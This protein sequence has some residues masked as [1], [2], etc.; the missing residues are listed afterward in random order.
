MVDYTSTSGYV[1]DDKGRRQYIDRNDAA[2]V[3]GTYL[4]ASD[5][6]QDRNAIMD[7][8]ITA[9]LKGSAD[10]DT[11]LTR[12]IVIL[13][14]KSAESIQENL[15]SEAQTR[16]SA[17]KQLQST[18]QDMLGFVPVSGQWA[19]GTTSY[20]VLGL[21]YLI[22]ALRPQCFY[23]DAD[24][25]QHT[26]GVLALESDVNSEA[27]ARESADAG[28][29]GNI[30]AEAAARA[31]AIAQC[32]SGVWAIG[33]TAYQITGLTHLISAERP[34]YFYQD[35]RGAQ[36]AGGTLALESDVTSEASARESADA[37][38]QGNI[39]AEA[40]ARASADAKLVS[41]VWAMGTTAY[42]ITGLTYLISAG[43]PQYYYEDGSGNQYAGGTL[44]LESDVT[45]EASARESADA[46]LQGNINAEAAARASADAK[47]VSGVWAMG[48]TAYQITGLT[49]LIA[50]GRPQYFYEDSSGG[51]H[52]GGELML[53]SDVTMTKFSNG[54]TRYTNSSAGTY[55]EHWF[56]VAAQDQQEIG[57]PTA[58]SRVDSLQLTIDMG[59]SNT[60]PKSV[61]TNYVEGTLTGTGFKVSLKTPA[62]SDQA[63][64]GL[65]NIYVAGWL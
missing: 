43:R 29:Q 61:A 18:K 26:G 15:N 5:R 30:N 46:G 34:Q 36:Y 64:G 3:Q 40:A 28:L 65:L 6:N 20:Q 22:S 56:N 17:D 9:G 38:L 10:D 35:S 23:Q 16:A 4:M 45:S 63:A 57:F 53:R 32:V 59:Y 12:A 60:S 7:P 50:D 31:N 51:Q 49:H 25:V 2:G 58:L 44:A 1:T 21:T 33:T 55:V 8:I 42:Q 48:T 47:L 14:G 62:E 54:S 11:L 19:L 37:G 13:A 24:G 27:S 41:G 52:T 39:N